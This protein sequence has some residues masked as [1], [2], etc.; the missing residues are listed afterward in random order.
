MAK[1]VTCPDGTVKKKHGWL[2]RAVGRGECPPPIKEVFGTIGVS[3][4]GGVGGLVTGG[5]AGFFAGAAAAGLS[6]EKQLEAD[7]KNMI[8]T[9]PLTTMSI[10]NPLVGGAAIGQAFINP[11]GSVTVPTNQSGSGIWATLINA[12]AAVATAAIGNKNN[13]QVMPNVAGNIGGNIPIVTGT[14]YGLYGGGADF[15]NGVTFASNRSGD[16]MGSGLPPWLL[17]VALAFGALL[18]LK[19]LFKL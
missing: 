6:R 10:V 9:A 11:S 3:L 19:K 12:G 4:A 17:P 13:Q 8:D 14:Q 15:A 1:Y 5:P 18:I 16:N 2:R 7:R